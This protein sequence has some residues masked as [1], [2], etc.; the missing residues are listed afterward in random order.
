MVLPLASEPAEAAVLSDR[1][2]SRSALAFV[3]G[4]GLAIVLTGAATIAL[5]LGEG[6]AGDSNGAIR[7]MLVVS[8]VVSAGMAGILLHRLLRVA[9]AWREA[10]SGAR[11]HVRF[12]TLFS[13]AA[14]APAII[15]A[16]FLGF[17]FSQ[18]VD[19]WFSE[20]V[21][22]TIENAADV[23]RAYVNLASEGLG[24]EVEAMAEDLNLA[25]RGLTDDSARY[26]SYLQLQAE[27]RGFSSAYVID[28]NGLV[29]AGESGVI[30]E[31]R[32]YFSN[33]PLRDDMPKRFL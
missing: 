33:F 28:S 26:E 10:A 27:R 22:S 14:L 30:E 29:L 21:E 31:A 16:A 23:G 32:P 12:V 20:R 6:L 17:T 4:L 18:G 13:L 11:L 2:Q 24:G 25:Q 7:G 1:P 15:V 19:R 5:L 9:R 3:I 8:L